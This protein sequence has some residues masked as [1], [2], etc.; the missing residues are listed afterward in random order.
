MNQAYG[1]QGSTSLALKWAGQLTNDGS[2]DAIVGLWKSQ[3]YFD[4]RN[5]FI[6]YVGPSQNVLFADRDDNIG[7]FTAGTIPLRRQGHSGQVPVRGDGT[8]DYLGYVSTLSLPYVVNP[9]KAFLVTANNSPLPY[10]APFLMNV[11]YPYPYRAKRITNLIEGFINVNRNFTLPDMVNIQNDVY[12]EVFFRLQPILMQLGVLGTTYEGLRQSLISWNGIENV[13]GNNLQATVFEAWLMDLGKIVGPIRGYSRNPEYILQVITGVIPG[14]NC[15]NLD[16]PNIVNCMNYA[17]RRFE[18]AIDNLIAKYGKIPRWGQDIHRSQFPNSILTNSPISCL[19]DSSV[20]TPGGTE[21]VF[22]N[23]PAGNDSSVFPM[24]A[25]LGPVYKQIVDMNNTENSMFIGTPGQSG[26]I[27]G[28][29]YRNLIQIWVSGSVTPSVAGYIPM[30]T[31][32][33]NLPTSNAIKEV[34]EINS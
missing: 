14:V 28:S 23:V 21:T 34:L 1:I 27:L 19:S 7:Y 3:N 12:S 31:Q 24:D 18:I 11:E 8:M 33:Y 20:F 16:L 6:N 26:N 13:N 17:Q 5:Y 29:F 2:I 4:F 9:P 22:E 15:T 25:Y 32:L 10:G 30:Q